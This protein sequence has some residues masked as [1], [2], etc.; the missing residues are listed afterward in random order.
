MQASLGKSNTLS[1]GLS[2]DQE[3]GLKGV[4]GHWRRSF[5]GKPKSDILL[6]ALSRFG[7]TK[8][9]S[10]MIGDR[11]YTDIA[12]GYNEGIDTIFVLSGEETVKDAEESDTKP[13]YIIDNIREVYNRIK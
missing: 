10:V 5:I 2:L 13:T 6:I 3:L 12:S 4:W 11:L 8:E 7:Y 9:E 1:L